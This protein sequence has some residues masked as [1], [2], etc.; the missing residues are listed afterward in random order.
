VNVLPQDDKINDLALNSEFRDF[1]DAIQYLTAI[2]NDQDLIVTR[3]QADFK[4]SKLP[5]MTAGEFI[6][7]IKS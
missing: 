1:E 5:V 3:N 4:E 2:E 6:K 7:S